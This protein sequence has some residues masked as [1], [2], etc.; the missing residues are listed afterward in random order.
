M[1]ARSGGEGDRWAPPTDRCDLTL[2]RLERVGR[3]PKE[4]TGAAHQRS[5]GGDDDREQHGH[6]G[7]PGIGAVGAVGPVGGGRLEDRRGEL[8]RGAGLDRRG[9]GLAGW[10]H[11]RMGSREEETDHER[12]HGEPGDE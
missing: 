9:R 10:R 4:P 8:A 7:Q 6:R 5:E 11:E 3:E 2:G 1:D 12:A